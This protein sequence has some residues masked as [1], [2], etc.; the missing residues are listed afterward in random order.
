[1]SL[2]KVERAFLLPY[3]QQ[4]LD[5]GLQLIEHEIVAKK[6]HLSCPLRRA[7]KN[8]LLEISAIPEVEMAIYLL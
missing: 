2:S 8:S 1:M 4:G 3:A 6:S 7:V 5:L